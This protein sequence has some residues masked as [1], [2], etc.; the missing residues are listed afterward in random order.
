MSAGIKGVQHH[1]WFFKNWVWVWVC[2]CVSMHVHMYAWE[3]NS[4]IGYESWSSPSTV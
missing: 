1:N 2:V 4:D 3:K